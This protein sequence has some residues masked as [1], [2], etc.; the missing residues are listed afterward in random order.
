LLPA[1]GTFIGRFQDFLKNNAYKY[2]EYGLF[3]IEDVLD[4][5]FLGNKT[6]E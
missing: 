2:I 6:D 5:L 1:Y 4:S 3:D